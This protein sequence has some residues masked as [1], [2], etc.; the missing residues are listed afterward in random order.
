MNL[1]EWY[2][3]TPKG[4]RGGLQESLSKKISVS[5]HT[6]RSY[7][8]GKRLVPMKHAIDVCEFTNGNVTLESMAES[9]RCVL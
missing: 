1:K 7:L 8:I 3:S 4:E 5:V 9:A 6:A 2:L